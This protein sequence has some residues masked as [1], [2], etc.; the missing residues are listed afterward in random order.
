[1]I[2]LPKILLF[3]IFGTI[4]ALTFTGSCI[5]MLDKVFVDLLEHNLT[6][7]EA[8]MFASLISGEPVFLSALSSDIYFVLHISRAEFRKLF[9]STLGTSPYWSG[10]HTPLQR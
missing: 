10:S 8:M 5:Y 3:A 1:M 9:P 6:V 4:T 2:R 7:A